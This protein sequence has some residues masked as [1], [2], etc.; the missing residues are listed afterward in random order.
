MTK[1]YQILYQ[2]NMQGKVDTSTGQR[3][4]LAAFE[5]GESKL[6]LLQYL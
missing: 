2:N 3:C 5:E 4:T 1:L 6:A